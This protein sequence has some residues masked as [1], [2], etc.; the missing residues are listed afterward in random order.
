[1]TTTRQDREAIARLYESAPR[2]VHYMGASGERHVPST[3]VCG[4]TIGRGHSWSHSLSRVT[5]PVCK[6]WAPD[7][8]E[9]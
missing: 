8:V 3:V 2:I 7:A 9:G 4:A 6:E 1:M 5:C